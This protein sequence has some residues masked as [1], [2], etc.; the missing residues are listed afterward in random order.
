MPVKKRI[1]EACETNNQCFTNNCYN[2]ICTSRNANVTSRRNRRS[3]NSI[4]FENIDLDNV[5]L[6]P[7]ITM[8]PAVATRDN[9]FNTDLANQ[10]CSICLMDFTENPEAFSCP[11]CRRFFHRSCAARWCNSN[12][13]ETCPLCRKSWSED[14]PFLIVELNQEEQTPNSPS[15]RSSQSI[16]IDNEMMESGMTSF[17]R[18]NRTYYLNEE[19]GDVYDDTGNLIGNEDVIDELEETRSIGGKKHKSKKKKKSKK[20]I[21]NSAAIYDTPKRKFKFTFL[22]GKKKSRKNKKK[23]LKKKSKKR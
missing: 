17:V 2:G 5:E 12:Q 3:N 4:D 16:D 1:G 20:T 8:R 18:N 13:S 23:K 19:N 21:Y 22:G 7:N 14:C 10:E 9:Q 6:N 11:H 15:N